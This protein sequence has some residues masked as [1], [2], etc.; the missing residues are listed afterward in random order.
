MSRQRI[1]SIL[2]LV[3]II[4]VS[5]IFIMIY[6][7]G[8][9]GTQVVIIVD[10][11]VYKTLPIHTDH[12]L[13]VETAEG[14]NVVTVQNDQVFVS[15]AD[16]ANQVCVNSRSISKNGEIIACIPHGLVIAITSPDKEVD[17]VA[18]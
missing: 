1:R 3:G 15:S 7:A 5:G 13:T 2:I 17:A 8:K 4:L 9:Q 11:Q 16:C 10:G 6:S 18:Y 12:T 14:Y